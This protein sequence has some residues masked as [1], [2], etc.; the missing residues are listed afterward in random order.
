MK[1]VDHTVGEFSRVLG[2]E[3]PAPGGGSASA[4]M[5]S[6]GAALV[7]MVANLSAGKEKYKEHEALIARLLSEAEEIRIAFLDV[8][9]R[10]T[11]AFNGVSAVFAMP[12]STDDEKAARRDAMQ[13]ALKACCA[14]PI[15]MMRLSLNA[16]TICR[17]AVGKTNGNAASDLG[18]AALALKA[19]VQG[20]NLNV[21]INLGG[22]RDGDFV[23]SCCAECDEILAKTLPL[24]DAAYEEVLGS[25]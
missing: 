14:T 21:L 22:I 25:L 1:L 7:Q 24:A 3:A 10:D 6:L 9:D 8:M 5:G 18:V 15:E 4:L 17:E 2:S 16:L 19:A 11:E 13:T 20:A 23:S 12:K